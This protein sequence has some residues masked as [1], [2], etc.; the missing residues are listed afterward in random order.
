[1]DK[2]RTLEIYGCFG[3]IWERLGPNR[4]KN[5][6]QKFVAD[7]ITR[8]ESIFEYVLKRY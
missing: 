6:D 2:S 3:E 5:E 7:S 8:S 1:M 4:E